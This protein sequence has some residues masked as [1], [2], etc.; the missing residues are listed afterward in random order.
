MRYPKIFAA[1]CALALCGCITVP[2]G[3]SDAF[4]AN[5]RILEIVAADQEGE[6]SERAAFDA[7][8]KRAERERLFAEM[9]ANTLESLDA[10]STATLTTDFVAY[11]FEVEKSINAFDA[12]LDTW[13]KRGAER[14]KWTR[15]AIANA[16]ATLDALKSA[17]ITPGAP[18]D[19]PQ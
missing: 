18:A 6:L 5:A 3:T 13:A 12:P 2:E 8:L 17:Q 4:G 19:V 7:S 15:Q 16:K 9:L 10:E 1:I 14:A 11:G